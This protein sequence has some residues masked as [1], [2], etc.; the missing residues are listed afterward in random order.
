MALDK[1]NSSNPDDLDALRKK[2]ISV[3]QSLDGTVDRAIQ[4]TVCD[5]IVSSWEHQRA[6]KFLNLSDKTTITEYIGRV[7]Q[8]YIEQ[9][10]YVEQ[11]KAGAD[12]VWE[13][14]Y[15]KMQRW[16][17]HF[18][19][20]NNFYAGKATFELAVT[21]AGEAAVVLLDA[22]YYYDTDAFEAWVVELVKNICRKFMKKATNQHVVPEANLFSID[23]AFDEVVVER[24]LEQSVQHRED[25]VAAL[26]RLSKKERAVLYG[27]L[28]GLKTDELAKS[29]DTSVSHVYKIKF[30]A[31]Q[32]MRKILGAE[33][34]NHE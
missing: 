33:G 29:L 28:N 5:I 9:H 34:Y 18:L 7:I 10:H 12:E 20:R 16:A 15:V 26:A 6:H 2:I 4:E 31:I 17:Y 11:V 27:I 24:E 30:D 19:L 14:L 21:Y 13:D 23:A 22:H 32:K 8:N 3:F 25:I 1:D